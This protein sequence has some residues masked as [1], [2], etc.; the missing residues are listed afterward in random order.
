M[1]Y[2]TPSHPLIRPFIGTYSLLEIAESMALLGDQP[3]AASLLLVS[4]DLHTLSDFAGNP[5]ALRWR[6]WVEKT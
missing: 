2:S 4:D 6:H 1:L 5:S 3:D